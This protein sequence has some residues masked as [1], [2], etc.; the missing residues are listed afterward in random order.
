MGFREAT[1]IQEQAIPV[2]MDGGDLIACAQ[3][4]TGKTAAFLLPTI[5]A[6]S[7][8]TSKSI[9]TLI[10]VPTRELAM[11]IDRQLVGF[12]YFTPVSSVAIYGGRDGKAFDQEKKALTTG[13]NIVIATPGRLIAHLNL[14]Y[15]KMDKLHSLIL[16]EADRMLDMGFIEDINKIISYMPKDRQTLMFSATMP[17][18][19]RRF[20][21][22]ILQ[23]PAE[24]S[25]ALSKPAENVTQTVYEVKEIAKAQLLKSILKARDLEN[26]RIVI[27]SGT[28]SKVKKMAST[29]K[30]ARVNVGEIHS[31][32]SQDQREE[33]I[34]L[35][36][37]GSVPV[38][39]ATDIVA[40]GI[41]VKGISLVINI[42]V[43][44]DAEDYVHRVGRTARADAKG[45]AM[46]FVSWGDR[47][48]LQQIEELIDMKVKR[49]P[50]PEFMADMKPEPGDDD[51]RG[52]GRGGRGGGRRGRS[53]GGG[54][55]RGGNRGG[56][57]GG[58]RRRRGGGGRGKS[59]GGGDQKK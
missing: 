4:G 43:P 54:R 11:Q 55:G 5:D 27:F 14:G 58:K 22:K 56:G 20:A 47:R 45:E 18:K 38:L 1:P 2:I 48:R 30:S 16:D 35:F 28:K 23:E 6:V 9:D 31:D 32:L 29:L 17:S 19:I 39:V 37:N 42:D 21:K 50:L 51:G 36:K 10:L 26:E 15:V 46:T 12:S 44:G 53:G 57:G 49:T 33:T 41:D 25:L 59:G 7:T 52:R 3:T 13:A 40:R 24:I 34:R 8:L